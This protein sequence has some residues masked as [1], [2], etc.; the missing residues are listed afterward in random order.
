MDRDGVAEDGLCAV[1]RLAAVLGR[2]VYGRGLVL[3][4]LLVHLRDGTADLGHA[5][6]GPKQLLVRK[7]AADL[8]LRQPA[9]VFVRRDE[10]LLELRERVVPLLD[11]N[12]PGTS[13]ALVSGTSSRK[14][15]LTL[16]LPC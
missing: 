5:A 1:D 7:Q 3:L 9:E 13:A 12:Q 15:D 11:L 8:L 4:V 2:L 14:K 6:L 16:G 10:R